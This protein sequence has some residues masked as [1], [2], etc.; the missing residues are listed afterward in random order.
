MQVTRAADYGVRVMVHLAGLPSGQRATRDE[1]AA[2]SEVPE[3]FLSKILQT[4]SR[5]GLITS[6]R[7]A[8]GG[9]ALAKPP[10]FVT[11][12]DVVEAVDGPI[13]L[14]VCVAAGVGCCRV[15]RCV[16]H[17]VWADAQNALTAV[18]RGATLARLA[19]ESQVN[20]AWS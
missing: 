7:G 14:N 6:H 1:L 17:H 8:S 9:F 3:H 2:S 18:L 15:T 20:C 12:L 11:L 16:V 4:L 13:Q 10:E 5:G 19:A